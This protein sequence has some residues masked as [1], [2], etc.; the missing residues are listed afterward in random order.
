MMERNGENNMRILN[1]KTFPTDWIIAISSSDMEGIR[2]LRYSGTE[3]HVKQKL[4]DLVAADRNSLKET[5][6]FGT[7]TVEDVEDVSNRLGYEFYAMGNY[8]GFRI[9]YT[10]KEFAHVAEI[11]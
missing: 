6:N 1:N 10:A 3:D 2:I 9:D 7:E 4:V 5:W 8:E 11:M